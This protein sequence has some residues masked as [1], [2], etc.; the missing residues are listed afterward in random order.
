[1]CQILGKNCT[2]DGCWQEAK[3]FRAIGL[4]YITRGWEHQNFFPQLKYSLLVEHLNMNSMQSRLLNQA[5]HD[6]S[7]ICGIYQR[8]HNTAFSEAW[9]LRGISAFAYPTDFSRCHTL[10][11]FQRNAIDCLWVGPGN[12]AVIVSRR[13]SSHKCLKCASHCSP[14]ALYKML[15]LGGEGRGRKGM[16][17]ANSAGIVFFILQQSKL[18]PSRLHCSADVTVLRIRKLSNDTFIRWAQWVAKAS[19]R[20]NGA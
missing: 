7:A 4:Q 11:Q 6:C 17:R 15:R 10:L 14:I 19:Q 16:H 12:T 9:Q 1:M 13:Q 3:R 2:G 18:D 8:G 5:L 20:V